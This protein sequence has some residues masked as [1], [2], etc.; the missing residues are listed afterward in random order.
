MTTATEDNETATEAAFGVAGMDCA[1]CVAPV[2][3]AVHRVGGGREWQVDRARGRAVV[4]FDPEKTNATEI[5]GAISNAGYPATPEDVRESQASAEEARLNRQRDEARSWFR[6]A[7]IAIALWLPVELLHW[8]RQLA[9]VHAHDVAWI[10]WLSLI[11]STIGIAYVG[12]A[13]YR[14][15][16]KAL[17]RRTS[18]MDTLISMGATVAYVY[19]L[20]ALIGH[21]A[22]GWPLP[23]LY[24]TE[25]TGLLALISLGHWLEA[26]A[27]ESA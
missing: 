13:F 9:G 4:R 15:A 12:W 18:N 21:L 23:E 7:V 10:T 20:G 1:S 11:T 25:S 14:S 5:A 2:G 17:L 24:F 22:R 3:E 6:R 16:F 8:G 26:R 27:R 19:S